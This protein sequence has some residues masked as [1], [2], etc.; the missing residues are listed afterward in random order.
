MVETTLESL[1]GTLTPEQQTQINEA[2]ESALAT[3]DEAFGKIDEDDSGFIE[4]EEL[5][6][7]V[8]NASAHLPGQAGGDKVTEFI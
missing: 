4:R 3:A 6:T 1:V 7:L 2:R 8:Q 5:T